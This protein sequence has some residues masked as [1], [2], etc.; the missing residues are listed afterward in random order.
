MGV[1]YY[2]CNMTRKERVD[3]NYGKFGEFDFQW[4]WEEAIIGIDDWLTT[5]EYKWVSDEM[6]FI[7]LPLQSPFP[8]EDIGKVYQ[9][10]MTVEEFEEKWDGMD[11]DGLDWEEKYEEYFDDDFDSFQEIIKGFKQRSHLKNTS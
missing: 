9:N 5:D 6:S 11:I 7:S 2:L 8:F 1:W 4:E 10:E 3:H